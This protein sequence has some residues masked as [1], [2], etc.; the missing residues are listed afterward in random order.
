MFVF[1]NKV[2]C[3]DLT[4]CFENQGRSY[5]SYSLMAIFQ[6]VKHFCIKCFREIYIL[7]K[8][9]ACITIGMSTILTFHGVKPKLFVRVTNTYYISFTSFFFAKGFSFRLFLL[10]WRTRGSQAV[11]KRLKV[12]ES[13]FFCESS[14]LFSLDRYPPRKY[15]EPGNPLI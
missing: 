3:L 5:A 4:Y 7:K 2:S 15:G 6:Q 11:W 12:R 13:S 1:S 14:R 8:K 10:H 9:I